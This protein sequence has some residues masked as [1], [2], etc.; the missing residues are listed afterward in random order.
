MVKGSIKFS[1]FKMASKL[2]AANTRLA[3]PGSPTDTPEITI[4]PV[5]KSY[6]SMASMAA[7][8]F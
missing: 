8:R 2:S 1:P 5:L 7:C 3:L 4:L 6:L